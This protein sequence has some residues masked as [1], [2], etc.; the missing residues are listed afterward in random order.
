M[1]SPPSF[2]PCLGVL[3]FLSQ[4]LLYLSLPASYWMNCGV[5]GPSC[6]TRQI[7]LEPP[8][9]SPS[10]GHPGRLRGLS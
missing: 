10:M 5:H 7:A 6:A 3:L 2:A 4:L 1:L 8:P 9:K